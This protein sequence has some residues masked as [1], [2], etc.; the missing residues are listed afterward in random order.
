MDTLP[1]KMRGSVA[2]ALCTAYCASQGYIVSQPLFD[3]ASYDLIIDNGS[4]L[5]KVQCKLTTVCT[6][7]NPG[8][9]A[10]YPRVTLSVGGRSRVLESQRYTIASFDLLWIMTATS[11]YLIPAKDIF[12]TKA[13]KLELRLYPKWNK[14]LVDFP[15][16]AGQQSLGRILASR[17]TSSEQ[18]RIVALFDSGMT[19]ETIAD[20]LGLTRSCVSVYLSRAGMQ[21]TPPAL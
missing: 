5:Q 6:S 7:P 15:H 16:P 2:H 18:K 21:R 13:S 3:N 19:T 4:S 17:L 8:M 9:T 1:S 10:S 12:A 20:T 11:F 14:F